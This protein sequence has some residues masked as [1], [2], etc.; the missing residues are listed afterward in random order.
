MLRGDRDVGAAA[1]S[2][3]LDEQE[4]DEA[5][6]GPRRGAASSICA[7]TRRSTPSPAPRRCASSRSAH[8][9]T[10]NCSK[11]LDPKGRRGIP[12]G[13]ARPSGS[14]FAAAAAGGAG[15]RRL[16]VRQPLSVL[17]ADRRSRPGARR[18]LH[19]PTTART[20]RPAPGAPPLRCPS[21]PHGAA[22][23]RSGS[24]RPSN[25]RST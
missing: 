24:T 7:R 2:R 22:S 18:V 14:Y 15:G 6:Q 4:V 12:L 9:A 23:T 13:M 5:L 19:R 25:S 1:A 16:A 17:E 3:K 10:M 8:R 21:L 20:R 11:T